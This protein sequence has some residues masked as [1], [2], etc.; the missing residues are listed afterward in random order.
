MEHRGFWRDPRG[1][2]ARREAVGVGAWAATAAVS[3]PRSCQWSPPELARPRRRSQTWCSGGG[4][5]G[6]RWRSAG[7]AAHALGGQKRDPWRGE[8]PHVP[9]SKPGPPARCED[10]SST[11]LSLTWG[12]GLP[13]TRLAR[14]PRGNPKSKLIAPLC[15]SPIIPPPALPPTS[16]LSLLPQ[17]SSPAPVWQPFSE[18][19]PNHNCFRGPGLRATLENYRF[20]LCKLATCL[21]DT[22]L[23]A[24]PALPAPPRPGTP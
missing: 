4:Q 20:A 3:P 5:V 12:W 6:A 7:A 16:S 2:G 8:V 1:W 9:Q 22:A 17:I 19:C 13:A 14:H 11:G 18:P 24:C 21:V 15:A 10:D 23:Y